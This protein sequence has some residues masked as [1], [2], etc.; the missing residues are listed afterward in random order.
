MNRKAEE[1]RDFENEENAEDKKF[2][3]VLAAE[4][5]LRIVV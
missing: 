3:V 5:Q 1:M 2:M 4:T